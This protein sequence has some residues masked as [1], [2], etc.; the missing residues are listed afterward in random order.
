MVATRSFALKRQD[1]LPEEP[2]KPPRRVVPADS[3]EFSQQDSDQHRPTADYARAKADALE[4]YADPSS[5]RSLWNCRW[6][7]IDCHTD[8]L[9]RETRQVPPY[10]G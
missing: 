10:Q 1:F 3:A 4:S 7:S 2:F 6:D 9:P 5:L 8:L